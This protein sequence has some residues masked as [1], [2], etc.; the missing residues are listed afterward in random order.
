MASSRRQRL[1]RQARQARFLAAYARTGTILHAA[2]ESG[3]ERRLHYRWLDE[4]PAYA[5][6]FAEAEVA[7]VEML[8]REARRRAVDGVEE[9]IYWQGQKID[10]LRKYSDALLIFL[11]K[12][13]RPDKYRERVDL[14]HTVGDLS[15][16]SP[17]ELQQLRAIVTK[18]RGESTPTMV[19][20]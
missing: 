3:I 14:A 2:L 9:P 10:T 19:A 20:A 11:L 1:T 6:T 7:A 17:D 12:A 15:R 16:L 13:A 18:A 5:A 4:D 8:E